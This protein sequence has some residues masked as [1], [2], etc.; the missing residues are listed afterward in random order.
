MSPATSFR[1]E[2][3]SLYVVDRI[4]TGSPCNPSP[5]Y[6]PRQAWRVGMPALDASSALHRQTSTQARHSGSL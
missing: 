2:M 1:V 6:S 4:N 5:G 3:K